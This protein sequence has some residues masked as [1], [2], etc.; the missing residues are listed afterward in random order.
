[1]GLLGRTVGG[2]GNRHRWR[3]MYL[4]CRLECYI[5]ANEKVAELGDFLI[6]ETEL[7][8]YIPG[9]PVDGRRAPRT[10]TDE[11]VVPGSSVIVSA[12]QA[13][14][15]IKFN[16]RLGNFIVPHVSSPIQACPVGPAHG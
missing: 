5:N 4:H 15:Q 12:P 11:V 3:Y 1:M 6:P 9:W 16:I 8:L 7:T 2:K 13:M 10:A 14:S